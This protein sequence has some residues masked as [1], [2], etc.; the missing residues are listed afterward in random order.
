MSDHWDFF[1]KIA[2]CSVCPNETILYKIGAKGDCL[3]YMNLNILCSWSYQF[4]EAIVIKKYTTIQP[5]GLQ[6]Y[7][8]IW[9]LS[10]DHDFK[11]FSLNTYKVVFILRSVSPMRCELWA[12]IQSPRKFFLP[13]KHE[14]YVSKFS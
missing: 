14:K 11:K 10:L 7:N 2:K 8:S 1:H 6:N 12:L 5:A 4:M 3:I 13:K 9:T